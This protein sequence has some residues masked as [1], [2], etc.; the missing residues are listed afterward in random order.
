[1]YRAEC[2]NLIKLI[3]IFKHEEYQNLNIHGHFEKE[4]EQS[5]IERSNDIEEEIGDKTVLFEEN[6]FEVSNVFDNEN[7]ANNEVK[8]VNKLE[9]KDYSYIIKNVH[10]NS[11]FIQLDY[12]DKTIII[13]IR[14]SNYIWLL[15]ECNG[16]VSNDRLR[17]FIINNKE[18][19][20]KGEKI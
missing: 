6:N 20:K 4:D 16:K 12:G 7:K 3:L 2:A 15:D 13:I 8:D 14:K 1:M 17:R 10:R 18:I 19:R 5:D 9:L 11:K